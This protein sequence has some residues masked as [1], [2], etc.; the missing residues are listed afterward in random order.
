[1]AH[2]KT[3]KL[4]REYR[5]YTSW[6]GMKAR[7]YNTNNYNY[8]K[9]GGRGII[10]CER[11][12]GK[13]GFRNF[14]EDMGERPEGYSIERINVNGNYELS[15]CKWATILEQN[16]NKTSN[17]K[18]TYKGIEYNAANLAKKFGIEKST[19]F[20]R[21]EA[22]HRGEKLVRPV[23][24][25]LRQKGENYTGKILEVCKSIQGFFTT[26]D[27]KRI[28]PSDIVENI[29]PNMARSCVHEFVK[30][31]LIGRVPG[32]KVRSAHVYTNSIIRNGGL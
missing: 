12:L 29:R 14:L 15:N 30:K 5:C 26:S 25:D 28:L 23:K 6:D 7:C 8:S 1:M 22:G 17:I 19:F 4:C 24:Q 21:I 13:Y 32:V 18:I 31:G 16:N 20:K 27:L 11:W 2:R 3:E 10:I 9:Y